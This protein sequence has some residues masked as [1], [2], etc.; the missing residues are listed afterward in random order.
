[1]SELKD[2][3]AIINDSMYDLAAKFAKMYQDDG[4]NFINCFVK[5][6]G[7]KMAC[8][9]IRAACRKDWSEF[10]RGKDFR[11]YCNKFPL[12]DMEKDLMNDTLKIIY[13]ICSMPTQ[14]R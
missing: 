3:H 11:E 1:M 4:K 5:F 10:E 14:S 9:F 2:I 8:G 13:A 7:I 12:T 6:K